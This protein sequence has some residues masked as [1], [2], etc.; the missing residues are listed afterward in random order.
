MMQRLMGRLPTGDAEPWV[1]KSISID[2]SGNTVVS[3]PDHLKGI[4]NLAG[5]YAQFYQHSPYTITGASI[6][7]ND[8]EAGTMTLLGKFKDQ[9]TNYIIKNCRQLMTQPG[10]WACIKQPDGTFKLYY[11]PVSQEEVASML[12]A[13]PATQVRN[14]NDFIVG[15]YDLSHIVVEGL[16]V[17][18]ASGAGDGIRAERCE[19][20]TI[21]NN[22][23][24]DNGG[25]I[26][27]DGKAITVRGAGIFLS[28]VNGGKVTGNIVTLNTQGIGIDSSKDVVISGNDVG[29][30][31]ID[32]FDLSSGNNLSTP[33]EN[34]TISNNYIHHQFNLHLHADAIQTYDSGV[35]NLH[36]V[37]NVMMCAPQLM[38]NGLGGGDYVGNV[39]WGP[40]I[41]QLAHKDGLGF[42]GPV[43]FKNNTYYG[44]VAFWDAM[45]VSATENIVTGRWTTYSANYTG[46]RNL[47]QA[48]QVSPGVYDASPLI[49]INEAK[50]W[51]MIGENTGG[52]QAF[53][54]LTGQDEHS[55]FAP[56]G[57]SLFVNMPTAIRM[58]GD[59]TLIK[60]TETSMTMPI[61]KTA[62][63]G[64][65]KKDATVGFDVGGY[66]EFNMDGV[67]RQISAIDTE[68]STITFSP[69][70]PARAHVTREDIIE[71]WGNRTDFKRDSRL[72]AD[73]PGGAMAADG[74]PV[75]SKLI[76]GNFQA[77]DFDGDG[78]RDLPELPLM[79]RRT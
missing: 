13:S 40:N 6:V 72:A 41:N 35:Q 48:L 20:V 27:R 2:A 51:R 69:P 46:D 7:S 45:P 33:T 23:A 24:H 34:I 8:P 38:H 73:S 4:G 66:I 62:L 58:S 11:W 61:E 17:M 39:I 68:N 74:G 76:I 3:D 67:P 53:F 19:D 52:I 30:N 10:D 59:I 47:F 9:S 25:Y 71:Y 78:K 31:N 29:Y 70:L 54:E 5:G 64:S 1:W 44:N 37:D 50:Q 63:E 32:G 42:V 49:S 28:N 60:R 12:S 65:G 15:I 21:R 18:G 14:A 79:L 55:Q 75:G 22:I 36:I 16:E 26:W 57:P 56:E 43:T 77:G